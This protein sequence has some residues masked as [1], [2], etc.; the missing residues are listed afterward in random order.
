MPRRLTA[1]EYAS[2]TARRKIA[3]LFGTP[4]DVI[5]R[6]LEKVLIDATSCNPMGSPPEVLARLSEYISHLVDRL[7]ESFETRFH[8]DAA[9]IKC[10]EHDWSADLAFSNMIVPRH[11]RQWG[12]ERL[13]M[14]SENASSTH[15]IDLIHMPGQ[16]RLEDVD[17]LSYPW[18]IHELGHYILLHN[19]HSFIP[20]FTAELSKTTSHLRLASI[21][22]RGLARSRAQR[23]LEELTRFWTPSRDQ[24]NWAHELTI[25]LIALWT[26]GP[27][28]LASFF[29]VVEDSKINP[30]EITQ[31]HPPYAVR[32]E[33]LIKGALLLD[34]HR[35]ST[36]LERLAQSWRRST[37]RKHFNN[38]F[39]AF[40]RAE[41]LDSSVKV[42]FSLCALLNLAKCTPVKIDAVFARPLSQT[43]ED[44]GLD[45]ILW[46]WA[47][48]EQ[49]GKEAYF[50][51]ESGTVRHLA[52]TIMQ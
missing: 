36:K 43:P 13:V 27:A 24:R 11:G 29:D 9:L 22:D 42:A 18:I 40:S 4:L 39:L 33:A 45:L 30:Y 49:K 51:W 52:Q 31:S 8:F 46:A 48:F 38:R 50:P 41:L 10:L 44:L 47:V 5:G 28:Y 3:R 23:T 15:V 21:A 35:Y 6:K 37:W 26:C 2:E 17:L 32:A 19:E 7:P 16:D 25:D 34:I 1:Q 14:P 12:H 20:D